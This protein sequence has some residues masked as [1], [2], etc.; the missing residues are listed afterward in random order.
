MLIK[1][2]RFPDMKLT[3][4][5]ELAL[6][7]ASRSEMRTFRHGCILIHR[8]KISSLGYNKYS[9]KFLNLKERFTTTCHAEINCLQNC[10][11]RRKIHESVLFVVRTSALGCVSESKPCKIC[12]SKIRSLGIKKVMY[13]ISP[14]Q[15]GIIRL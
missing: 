6:E 12:M 14:N 15:I 2:G 3:K 1:K 13:S 4:M 7:L 11:D 10:T 5:M 8:N 9:D